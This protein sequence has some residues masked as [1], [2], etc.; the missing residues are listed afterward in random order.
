MSNAT[1]NLPASRRPDAPESAGA[2]R[3]SLSRSRDDKST[4]AWAWEVIRIFCRQNFDWLVSAGIHA[5]VL[6]CIAGIAL[7]QAQK[8]EGIGIEAAN[9]P[10]AE[11]AFENVL[12]NDVP[13]MGGG[14][15]PFESALQADDVGNR[16]SDI[17][18]MKEFLKIGSGSNGIGDGGS[19]GGSGGGTGT[20]TGPGIGAGFF[21]TT[22]AGKSFVYVVDMSGSMTGR[23]FDRAKAELVKSIN[24]LNAEQKFYIY[25]FNDRTFPLFEPKPAKDMVPANSTNKERA[26]RW[27]GLRHAE[28]TTNPNYALQQALEMR[29]EVIFLLTDGELDDP[30]AV[31]YMIRKYNKTK[32]V[33]H[34][35]AFENEDGGLTLEA[36][37][38]ENDGIYRFVK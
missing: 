28:S 19:G 17:D 33:I 35:I 4:I 26:R 22:G 21:G 2:P 25:F 31:R 15:K 20:G 12:G 1:V 7:H 23:R 6:L 34:T 16:A 37:A 27:I 5:L 32:V 29:P 30:D 9:I 3:S 36:I 38:Q 8:V 18:A 14:G 11:Q 10:L 24:K 13:Q